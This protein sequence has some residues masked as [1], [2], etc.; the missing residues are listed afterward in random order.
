MNKD[1][2]NFYCKSCSKTIVDFREKTVEEIK[3]SINKDTCGIFTMEQLPSQQQMKLSRQI[4]FYFFSVLSILGFTVRPFS[5]QAIQTKEETVIVDKESNTKD[6]NEGDEKA[7]KADTK[8]NKKGLFRKK[9][10]V[11]VIGCPNF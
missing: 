9:K 7:K 8:K 6:L 3:G 10:R 11:T 1:G 4:L 5:T 2:E